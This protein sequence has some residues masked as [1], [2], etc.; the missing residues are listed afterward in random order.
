MRGGDGRWGSHSVREIEYRCSRNFGIEERFAISHGTGEGVPAI[1]DVGEYLLVR[2]N[3]VA[4]DLSKHV[5]C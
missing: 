2:F 5:S 4:A 3:V 1:T